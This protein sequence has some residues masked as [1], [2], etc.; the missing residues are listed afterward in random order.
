MRRRTTWAALAALALALSV[1]GGTAAGGGSKTAKGKPI[2]IGA[3]VDLTKNM[4]PFDA[5]ALAAAQ[6]EIKRINAAGGVNGRPLQLKFINDQLDPQKTKQ[7]AV[8]LLSQG[9]DILWVTCDVDFATPAA[10]EGLKAGKLTIAPCI[11][12][13]EMSPLR[14]GSK[15]KLAFSFGNAAQDE[16]AAMAEYAYAHVGHSAVVVTDNLLR[17]FKD[18]CK[19]FTVRFKELGGDVV[20]Q[21]SFTQFDKTIQN[22]VTR[23]NGEKASIIAFCTSFGADQPAFVSGLRSLGNNTPIINSWAGDGAYWWTTNPQVTNYYYV[24]YASVWG[25]DPNP[26]VRS[27]IS[28]LK[29]AG[30][31]PQTGG[32]VTGAAAIQAIA[33]AIKQAG[34]STDG[35]KLAAIIVKFHKQPTISG[36]ISFSA[37]LHSVFGRP[38]RVVLV[39]DNKASVVGTITA[40]S[41]ANIH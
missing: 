23:V 10:Q 38:Y 20:A 19:A 14:F 3:A 24:T 37:S 39:N 40:K 7:A 12:T 28:A 13:D 25:D 26:Q 2:I 16:G 34:G 31:A 9:A 6:V 1:F 29:A 17:Y 11:G 32:F 8:Q 22:V 21:E 36:P 35:A 18:I 41:P 30:N 15:G 4:S 5:P 33:A 27:L